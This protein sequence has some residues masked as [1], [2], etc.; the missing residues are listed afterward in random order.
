MKC[1]KRGYSEERGAG[2]SHTT[3]EEERVIEEARR[4]GR[5]CKDGWQ[6]KETE[7]EGR[8]KKKVMKNVYNMIERRGREG[9]ERKYM[10]D[11]RDINK[12]RRLKRE[13]L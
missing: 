3:R 5:T 7:K 6:G 12:E 2:G 1:V 4:K 11:C 8:W 13:S 9:K 10:K